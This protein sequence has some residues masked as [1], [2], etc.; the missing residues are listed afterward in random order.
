MN[1]LRLFS[2]V[3]ALASG[4][5]MMGLSAS[6][7]RAQS[8]TNLLA[9]VVT[10]VASDP[11]ATEPGGGA[12]AG[13]GRFTITRSRGYYG[14][15]TE[16]TVLCA[17]GGTAVNGVDYQ[18]I[19]N[20]VVIPKGAWSVDVSVLPFADTLP[21][22]VET[23]SLRLLPVMC[24][25]IVPPVPDCYSVGAPSVAVVSIRDNPPPTNL[26]PVVTILTPAD[27]AG[28]VAPAV[29]PI[30][31]QASDPDGY[32][33]TVEFFAGTNSLGVTTNNPLSMSPVNPFQMVWSN[34]PPGQFVLTAKATDDRGAIAWSPPVTIWVKPPPPA[35]V[36][37]RATD[38]LAAEPGVLT[39]IDPG[40]FTISR[41]SGT[42]IDLPVFYTIGGTASNGV[43]Y[44]AISNRVVIP[45]GA[46][47][48]D[49]TILPLR[50]NLAEGIETVELR[51]VLPAICAATI[52]P[53]PPECY[54]IGQP[55]DAV[56]FITD[57]PG[58]T[59]LPPDVTIVTPTNGASFPAPLDLPIGAVA[60]DRD[61][62]VK[63]VEFFAGANSLGIFTNPPPPPPGSLPPTRLPMIVWSNVPPGQYV[64]T[65]KATDNGGAATISAPVS[66]TVQP[67]SGTNLP[68]VVSLLAT[69]PVA[70][71]G[72]NCLRWPGYPV[73]W[74]ISTPPPGG[75]NCPC[76]TSCGPNT[77]TF[78]VRRAGDTNAPLI[79]N[80]A[81]GGTASNGVDYLPLSGRVTIPAGV[82]AAAIVV[83]P[84]DDPLPEPVETII[85]TLVPPAVA[86]GT[87]PAYRIGFPA[88]AAAIIVD[89]DQPRPVTRWLPDRCFHFETPGTNGMGFRI[90]ASSNLVDWVALCTN[91]V[92]DGAIHFVDPD[93]SGAPTKFYRA[94]PADPAPQ[95]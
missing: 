1:A 81:I 75:T 38:P 93:A 61:G 33:S 24:P 58:L 23:V 73:C 34:V 84:T 19:S 74:P 21:E 45:K 83:V 6:E 57:Q 78:Q 85:L 76:L 62:Y 92:T 42:N 31:A 89:N 82:R 70:A 28:F 22:G 17:V 32:V 60:S 44:V 20:V 55:G 54:A 77:A 72:T 91:T 2:P 88:R 43:D 4:F 18:T 13:P 95:N 86:D 30:A 5:V 37:I 53:P 39:V 35:V 64:L 56:V 47:S 49:I 14:T 69:D 66:I 9:P 79:V 68:P 26:P 87:P 8:L 67:W 80:Y 7:C 15:N 50:D 46:W 16:L 36:T 12:A 41:A 40:V 29:V 71:E 11:V 25:A 65:A 90:E 10:V 63:T 52:W 27:G 59:N 48:A 3:L 51:L 94:V